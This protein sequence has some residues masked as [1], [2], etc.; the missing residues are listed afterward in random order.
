M[1][2]ADEIR[3][4]AQAQAAPTG[5][6]ERGRGGRG[7]GMTFLRIDPILAA[8]DADGD[9][10]ISADELSSAPASLKKLD[11]NLDGQLTEE[12]VRLNMPGRGGRGRGPDRN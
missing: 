9:G 10:V 2:T 12:E 11:K 8:L 4:T 7:E 5:G 1:L 6:R 3:L